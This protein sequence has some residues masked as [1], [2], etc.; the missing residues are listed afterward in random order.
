MKKIISMI[1]IIA[2]IAASLTGAGYAVSADAPYKEASTWAVSELDKAV[3]YGLITDRIKN[4]MNASITREE[5]AELAVRLYEKYTGKKAVTGDTSIFADTNNPEIFKAYVLNIVNGTDTYRKLFSPNNLITREQ[6]AAMLFRT[7]K[8][9]KPDA[10]LSSEGVSVFA[11]ERN[12][13]DWALENI[14]FMSKHGFLKGSGGRID[15]KGT[16]T[17]EMAVIIITRIFENYT[18]KGSGDS[19]NSSGIDSGSS[20]LYNLDHLVINDTEVF[21]DNFAIKQK[22]GFSY[23]FIESEMF[24][25]AFK[26]PYAGYYTYPEVDVSLSSISASW[27]DENGVLLKADMQ[28]G[29]AEAVINGVNTDIGMAPYRTNGKMFIPINYFMSVLG[30]DTEKSIKGDIL[31][32]Q[33]QDEF[34]EDILAGKWSD[35]NTNL[36]VGFQDI[37]TGAISLPSFATAYEFNEDGTYGM[38]MVS[39]G[40]FNDT[41]IAQK[42]RYRVMGN[43]IMFYDIVETVYKG[44]PFTLSYEDK[45][46]ER[47]QYSFINNY[48]H[49]ED[50][51]EISGFWFNRQ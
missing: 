45:L 47:P 15:P 21:W 7:I 44:S 32:I 1:A 11:D 17:R 23:I 29:N 9:M 3:G 4:K 39:A 25:Y 46:L 12:I 26:Y 34:P 48:N 10:D 51:I 36:F 30:M 6:V 40:G 13:S 22:D 20:G 28:E 38:R 50:R 41:F 19:N 24:K 49:V 42:G 14:R 2:I 8:A 35:T 33:Y 5:F 37:T 16:C 27:S 31:Y 18:P 43:T